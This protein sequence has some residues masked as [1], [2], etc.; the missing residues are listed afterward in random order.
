VV[1]EI[2]AAESEDD[3]SFYSDLSHCFYSFG[4]EVASELHGEA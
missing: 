2:L 1:G 3:D 4:A